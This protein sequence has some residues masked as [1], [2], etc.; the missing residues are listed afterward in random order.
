MDLSE[1]VL[2]EPNSPG[3]TDD[4]IKMFQDAKLMAL[5]VIDMERNNPAQYREYMSAFYKEISDPDVLADYE[6]CLSWA[7]T[8]IDEHIQN[9]AN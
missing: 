2:G 5:S 1:M 6:K 7:R 4:L 8:F 3:L 9:E